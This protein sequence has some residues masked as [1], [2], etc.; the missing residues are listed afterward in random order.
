MVIN[1]KYLWH[2]VPTNCTLSIYSFVHN[3]HSLWDISRQQYPYLFCI[4][5]MWYQSQVCT[6]SKG[7]YPLKTCFVLNTVNVVFKNHTK[8]SALLECQFPSE[9]VTKSSFCRSWDGD[10]FKAL[11]DKQ[12]K[13][14]RW[15]WAWLNSRVPAYVAGSWPTRFNLE[16]QFHSLVGEALTARWYLNNVWHCRA[17]R[18]QWKPKSSIAQDSEHFQ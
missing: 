11:E 5:Y 13:G 8:A 2:S 16:L 9:E 7:F 3:K 18:H 15:A 1:I 14:R 4:L 10:K 17:L 6:L 12:K